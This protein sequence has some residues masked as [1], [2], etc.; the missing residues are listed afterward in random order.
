MAIDTKVAHID[1]DVFE[2]IKEE[3]RLYG[4]KIGPYMSKVLSDHVELMEI[5]KNKPDFADF[6]F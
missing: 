1:R 6:D 5:R 2:K 3:A 4:Y